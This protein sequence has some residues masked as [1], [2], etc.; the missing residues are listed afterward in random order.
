MAWTA[1]TSGSGTRLWHSIKK[2][3]R[4]S[5]E[6]EVIQFLES[7]NEAL[8]VEQKLVNEQ[9]LQDPMCM[10]LKVGGEGGGGWTQEQCIELAQRWI[11]NRQTDPTKMEEHRRRSSE[12][13]ARTHQAGKIRYDI[14]KGRRHS[15]ESIEK[16]KKA[17]ANQ[18]GDRNSQFGSC[19]IR[20]NGTSMKIKRVDLDQFLGDGWSLGRKM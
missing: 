15:Q 6:L 5:F 7:R 16:M 12:R 9:L 13:L 4:E 11:Q 18:S 20:K 14:F 17:H 10:N 8:Q 2:Y 19:W 1:A 3:G